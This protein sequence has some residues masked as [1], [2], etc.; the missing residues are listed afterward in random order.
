MVSM[1]LNNKLEYVFSILGIA[2]TS[3]LV[4]LFHNLA[5]DLGSQ[6]LGDE[7]P[8]NTGLATI[9]YCT[10][11]VSSEP[12]RWASDASML[13][14]LFLPLLTYIICRRQLLRL[15]VWSALEI[16][17]VALASGSAFFLV[18]IHNDV[19]SW[20]LAAVALPSVSYSIATRNRMSG[21]R[22]S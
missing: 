4:F 18:W 2:C 13:T 1:E 6:C 3:A 22:L 14:V 16:L 12:W 21:K 19:A 11:T 20:W 17:A 10:Q 15:S 9:N 8:I 7:I 5:S